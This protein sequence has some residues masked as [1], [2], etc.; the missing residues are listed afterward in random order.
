MVTNS[1]KK[2]QD[3]KAV[4]LIASIL[5]PVVD[6]YNALSEDKRFLARDTLMKFERCFA[7][8]TQIVRIDDK[9]LFKDYLFVSHLV[10]LLPKSPA[11]K[12]D[13]NGKIQL[14]YAKLE[15]TFRGAI[16]L[17]GS[18]EFNPPKNTA[19]KIKSKKVNTLQRIIDK[20]NEQYEGD[21][22]SADK[23]ALDSV[24][25]MLMND[26]VVKQKLKEFAKTNDINMF[27]K[28][29]FP[30]EFQRVLLECFKKNDEAFN[31]LLSNDAFQTAVM[32]IMAKEIYKSFIQD[33]KKDN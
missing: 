2:K 27:M 14:E 21:F 17:E 12:I 7:F 18:G 8:V 31:R 13:I 16:T 19:P 29:I 4:G 30:G 22:G 28:S 20:V 26:P 33:D 32:T 6:R 24:F 1:G 15:E 23:V 11:E 5:K 3:A 10:H 25:E 9:D